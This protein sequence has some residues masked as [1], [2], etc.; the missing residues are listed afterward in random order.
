MEETTMKFK[1][2]VKTLT[3]AEIDEFLKSHRVGVLSMTD[4]KTTYAIPLAYSYDG[5]NIYLTMANQGRKSQYL[6]DNM[7]VCFIVYWIPEGF[8]APGKMSY[9]SIICDGVFD[10]ITDP[11]KLS[12]AVRTLEKQMGYPAGAMDKLLE[13]TLKNPQKSNFWKIKITS[14][15]G[16]G[17]EDFKE[18]FEE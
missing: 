16:K 1:T 11:E 6:K 13:M 14:L 4:G 5:E 3:R 7:P 10:H 18:E 17:V 12:A 15:G 2:N 8:G 9:T